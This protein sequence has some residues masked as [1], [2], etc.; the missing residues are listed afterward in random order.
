MKSQPKK[1]VVITN[2]AWGMLNFRMSLARSLKA[3]NHEVSLLTG[4]DAYIDLL[5]KSEF[6][7]HSFKLSRHSINPFREVLTFISM[8]R[9][10]QNKK[11]DV[12]ISYTVKPN[13]YASLIKFLY[14]YTL[15][16]NVTGLGQVYFRKE[17][18][19]LI[20]QFFV[21]RVLRKADILFF[22]NKEDRLVIDKAR[23]LKNTKIINGSGVDL[24]VF[25]FRK[26]KSLSKKVTFVLASRLI[27]SKGILEFCRASAL[28]KEKY[29]N[30]N[31]EIYG[32]MDT[33]YF[34][35][36]STKDIKSLEKKFPIKFIIGCDHLHLA[37]RKAH[38][39]VLPSY[40]NE[41]M[42]RILL[43]AASSGIPAITTNTVGCKKVVKHNI[44]GFICEAKSHKHLADTMNN[45]LK[46]RQT[47]YD[48]MCYN[49]RSLAESKFGVD[50][51]NAVYLDSIKRL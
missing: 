47:S 31:F 1:I 9:Y 39:I 49:T 41:G 30:V 19:Y 43:E 26:P 28:V 15:F 5:K 37:I 44:T 12:V 17:F 27:W 18:T 48:A 6:D 24:E 23:K 32:K 34:D 22:Q 8:W 13:F 33:E 42:P 16:V 51:I 2:V 3:K 25:S 38:F 45:A 11:P 29:G 40:Y 14:N 35:S 10:L 21:T 36:L 4:E 20:I 50:K 46:M 7:V